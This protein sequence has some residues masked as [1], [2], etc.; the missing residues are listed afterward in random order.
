MRAD[1]HKVVVERERGGSTQRN[2]KW[3]QR[4]PFVPDADYDDQPKFASSG[5]RRQY[6]HNS[7]WFTDVLGPL[8]GFLRCHLGRPWDKVYSELRQGLDVRKVTGRHIFEHLE[9]MVETDCSI[10]EDRKVY[11]YLRGYAVT[12]FY[13]HP[14]TKLL[15]F[16]P[17]QSARMRKKERLM[18]QEVDEI[19]LDRSRSYKLH[20]G[21]WY[22]VTYE[23]V[24]IAS[25]E[26]TRTVWDVVRRQ[27]VQLTWG[28]NRVAVSKRQCN[29]EEVLKIHARIAEWKKAVR[30]M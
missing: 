16:A 27:Q 25:R 15:C 22:F 19:T 18:R 21:Q 6:G 11:S 9:W 28:W 13:V 12:G 4:L 29:R 7:K 24:W 14:R 17:K 1:L 5:R 20:E 8:E 23:N 3:G 10:G 30:R 2:R 26:E